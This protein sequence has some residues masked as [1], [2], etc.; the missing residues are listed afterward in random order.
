[1][2]TSWTL[3][4]WQNKFPRFLGW[5]QVGYVERPQYLEL[6]RRDPPFTQWLARPHSS[7]VFSCTCWSNRLFDCLAY[8][9]R[10]QCDMR[11]CMSYRPDSANKGFMGSVMI[12]QNA[13]TVSKLCCRVFSL[14][15]CLLRYWDRLHCE[16]IH[17]HLLFLSEIAA[18]QSQH[19]D[20][21][22]VHEGQMHAC[23]EFQHHYSQAC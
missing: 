6:V 7:C 10:D 20:V 8:T 1:M 4:D 15:H 2:Q 23:V 9:L 12:L 17:Q 18:H 5:R 11:A 3:V 21:D 22:Y 14:H 16:I 13:A 19:F